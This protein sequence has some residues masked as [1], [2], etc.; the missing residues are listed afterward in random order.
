MLAKANR[1]VRGDDFRRIVRT[2]RRAGCDL[3]V[4]HRAR[5]EAAVARFG[6]IVS[7]K[8]GNAVIRNRVK[9]RLSEI[10]RAELGDIDTADIVI[11]AL[12]SSATADLATLRAGIAPLLV[13][14]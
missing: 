2:G 10:V 5:P 8:V 9:R 6:F 12:P 4:V 14:R 13:R 3:A 1:I 11:R 7:K